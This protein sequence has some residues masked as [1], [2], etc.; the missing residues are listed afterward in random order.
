[1]TGPAQDH[2]RMFAL[3]N[4]WANDRIFVAA[5]SLP[6]E[7]LAEDRNGFFK[8]VLGTL[9]HLVATDRIWMGRLEGNSPLG[10]RL[11]ETI[12]DHLPTLAEVRTQENQRIIAHVFALEE[13]DFAAPLEYKNNA[14]SQTQPVSHILAHLFNHQTHHRGQA[15]DLIGQIAGQEKTPS[16]DMVAYQRY[17]FPNDKP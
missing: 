6:P 14:G 13:A 11:D 10:Y 17:I 12:S 8:S 7:R 4:R 9:N 5:A 3:Y 1:M 16:L 2:F 15:H